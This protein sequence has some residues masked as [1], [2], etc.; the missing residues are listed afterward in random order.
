VC[1]GSSCRH[2]AAVYPWGAAAARRSAG[3][4]VPAEVVSPLQVGPCLCRPAAWFTTSRAG[5]DPDP[6]QEP[7]ISLIARSGSNVPAGTDG[8]TPHGPSET[9]GVL[10][11]SSISA[12]PPTCA[13]TPSR[14]PAGLHH[15]SPRPLPFR[16]VSITK[17]FVVPR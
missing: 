8:A 4:G 11:H 2:G 10:T 13:G 15:P 12:P 3:V 9:P 16:L 1:G 17:G 5:A 6:G 7:S 14:R